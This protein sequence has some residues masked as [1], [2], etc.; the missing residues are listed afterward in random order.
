M[1]AKIVMATLTAALAFMVVRQLKQ[2]SN[3]AKE[4]VNRQ[5]TD[6]QDRIVTL[7][8]D[9]HTGVFRPADPD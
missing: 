6:P 2:R 8:E 4:R 3:K 9:P 5:R 7:R 1:L